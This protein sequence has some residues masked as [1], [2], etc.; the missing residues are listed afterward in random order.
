MLNGVDEMR[1]SGRRLVPH[2]EIATFGGGCFWCLEAVFLLLR[3]VMGVQSGYAGGTI[4]NP[5]YELVSS[6]ASGH[7]EVVQI[8][9]DPSQISFEELLEVFFSAHDPTT[10]NRQG[11]DVGSQYRS[12]ILYSSEQ[13]RQQAQ[14]YVKRIEAQRV[15]EQPVLTQIVPL[16]AFYRAES[17]HQNY[18][19]EN[20]TQPYCN[21]VIAPKIHKIRKL[22]AS[23]LKAGV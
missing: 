1:W 10:L 17:Y 15:F 11:A 3:G 8:T 19:Q 4:P 13:Q 18:F 21:L 2:M 23:K 9:F 20:S 14:A 7:A 22:F 5:T 16:Q 6:G 12:I